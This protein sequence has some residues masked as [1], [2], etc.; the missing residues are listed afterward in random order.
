MQTKKSNKNKNPDPEA[1]T[2]MREINNT[3]LCKVIIEM[4]GNS[5]K[6]GN[7]CLMSHWSNKVDLHHLWTICLKS[8]VPHHS[9]NRV[10][11]ALLS[12][13]EPP[14]GLPE[15]LRHPQKYPPVLH[16]NKRKLTKTQ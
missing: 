8:A 16:K 4:S 15:S 7:S 9:I 10:G 11:G 3:G 14:D 2:Q 1:A 12:S 6:H 13:P 5:E